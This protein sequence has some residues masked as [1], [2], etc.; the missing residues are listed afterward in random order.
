MYN[1]AIITRNAHDFK[2]D[3]ATYDVEVRDRKSL[4]GSLFSAKPTINELF[5]EIRK[6]TKGFKHYISTKV[7]AKKWDSS[8][9]TTIYDVI[10]DCSTSIEVTNQRFYLNKSFERLKQLVG[11]FFMKGSGWMFD[12]VQDI[13]I[14]ISRY[15]P[16]AASSFIPLPDELNNSMTGLINIKNQGEDDFFK[17]CHLR[18]IN[19]KKT[20]PERVTRKRDKEILDSLD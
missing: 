1:T 12:E 4:E 7:S 14:R 8:S 15:D 10:Y 20:H 13:W 11:N 6:N 16:L 17:C 3:V 5:T 2:G 9:G 19:P 18:L